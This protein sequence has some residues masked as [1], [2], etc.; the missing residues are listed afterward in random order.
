MNFGILITLGYKVSG[1]KF[2]KKRERKNKAIPVLS[3]CQLICVERCARQCP[4]DGTNDQREPGTLLKNYTYV[5][6]CMRV[7][8]NNLSGKRRINISTT[9]ARLLMGIKRI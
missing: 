1:L 5:Y 2:R 6:M 4:F 3:T 8:Y 7:R 9:K